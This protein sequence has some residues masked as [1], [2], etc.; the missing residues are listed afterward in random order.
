[1]QIQTFADQIFFT[2]VRIDTAD[3]KGGYGAG[4]G[5]HFLH[6]SGDNQ[7]LYLVTN[8]HVAFGGNEGRFT[9]HAGANGTPEIGNVIPVNI[10]QHDWNKIWFGHPDPAVDIAICPLPAILDY[11]AKVS[12]KEVFFRT[13][14]S[15]NIPNEAEWNDFDA[16]E[17]VTFVGYPNGVWDTKNF[18]PVARRGTTASPIAVNFEGTPRFIID[19]S[20]FGGSSGSPVFV[21]S[22]GSF[23]SRNGG[24]I[25]GSRFH[26][27][28]VVAAVFFRTQMNDLVARPIPTH[29][30]IAV[31]QQE[32]IDLGIVFRANTVVENIEAALKAG[33]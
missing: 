2:T 20:V 29:S 7:Y 23:G 24:V 4:T 13:I 8:K 17:E 1:M 19:A 5:F 27:V 16:I 28:G 3:G 22:Q 15:E 30:N 10:G 11:A 18:L 32:M 6:K 14:S 33:R 12:C 26:F 25:I 21:M 9:F 31:A